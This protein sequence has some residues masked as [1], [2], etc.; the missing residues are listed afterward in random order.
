[1][2]HCKESVY[3]G[4]A[5]KHTHNQLSEAEKDLALPQTKWHSFYFSHGNR[6]YIELSTS[7]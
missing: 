1:V 6:Y 7:E 4:E 5:S 2:K 3:S